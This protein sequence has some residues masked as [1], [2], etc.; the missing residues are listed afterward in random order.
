[1]LELRNSGEVSRDLRGSAV[2]SRNSRSTVGRS[3]S[4]FSD[5]RFI[6]E[7]EGRLHLVLGWERELS[8]LK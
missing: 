3:V 4:R 7:T 8:E 1:M 2:T 6:G 5:R